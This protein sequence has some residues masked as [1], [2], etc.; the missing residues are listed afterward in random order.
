MCQMDYTWLSRLNSI[1]I[2]LIAKTPLKLAKLLL[3]GAT[4]L[5]PVVP[6]LETGGL[7][8]TDAPMPFFCT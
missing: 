3:A 7:P 8:L 2:A 6:V 4:G 5:E 1:P